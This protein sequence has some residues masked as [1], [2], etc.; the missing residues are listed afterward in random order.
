MAAKT[1]FVR[2]RV[3]LQLL[4]FGALAVTSDSKLSAAT[5]LGSPRFAPSPEQSV[6]WRGDGTGRYPGAT[7]PI[8]WERTTN[9]NGYATKGIVWMSPLPNLSAATPIIV[10]DK[11]FL[12]S[13]VSDVV[14]LDK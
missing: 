4:T 12:T 11:I 8:S 6:G 1:G 3:V 14:C 5:P 9:G 10:G 2:A 7:P 13:E